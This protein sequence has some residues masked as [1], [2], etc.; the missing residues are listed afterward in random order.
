MPSFQIIMMRTLILQFFAII[1]IQALENPTPSVLLKPRNFNPHPYK[2]E[3]KRFVLALSDGEDIGL[4]RK[5]YQQLV[6]RFRK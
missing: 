3:A 2:E 5:F 1:T 6:E 4:E